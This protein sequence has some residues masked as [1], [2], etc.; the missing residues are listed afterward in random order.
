[1]EAASGRKAAHVGKLGMIAAM[2]PKVILSS[3]L[4]SVS[5]S[6]LPHFDSSHG[7][8]GGLYTYDYPIFWGQVASFVP[9]DLLVL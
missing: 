4:L 8:R 2:T 9:C 6:F 3:Q 1:M 5:Q 7:L